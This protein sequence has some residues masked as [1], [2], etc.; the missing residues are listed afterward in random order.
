M[1]ELLLNRIESALPRLRIRRPW[2]RRWMRRSAVAMVLQLRNGELHILMIKRAEREGDVW[3]G[4]MAF[5]GGHL[6]PGDDHG[7][8]AAVRETEEETGLTLG[9]QDRCLG[10]L[11]DFRARPRRGL[12]MAVSPFVFLLQREVEFTPNYEVAEVV[13]VPLDF[14]LDNGNREELLWLGRLMGIRLPC[15]YFGG[16]CIWG[17]SLRMLDDLLAVAQRP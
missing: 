2:L 9:P 15:Y 11:S 1:S 4:H 12:G 13:W 14:L 10:R 16:R 6:D 8:A 7:F 5:P 3:S 17:L